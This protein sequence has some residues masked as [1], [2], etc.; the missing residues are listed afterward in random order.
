MRKERT[1]SAINTEGHLS[2]VLNVTVLIS[3]VQEKLI[4]KALCESSKGICFQS[5]LWLT[6]NQSS[7]YDSFHVYT[8]VYIGWEELQD[9]GGNVCVSGSAMQ[10]LWENYEL[11]SYVM[12][13]HTQGR[14]DRKPETQ[15]YAGESFSSFL[16]KKK[17]LHSINHFLTLLLFIFLL[18]PSVFSV[19]HCNLVFS[20]KYCI[21]YRSFDTICFNLLKRFIFISLL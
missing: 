5:L 20:H 13:K 16:L 19:A 6:G 17:H 4:N 14:P 2:S 9:G 10:G 18:L 15:E 12:R 21:S 8:F 3:T 1:N 7:Y 11:S